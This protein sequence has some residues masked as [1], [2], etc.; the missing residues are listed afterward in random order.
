MPDP[1]SFQELVKK[2]DLEAVKRA[3]HDEPA[4][5]A[6]RNEAGQSSFMLAK[7]YR[8]EEIAS[9]LQSVLPD[10]DFF[11]ACV[12]GQTSVVERALAKDSSLLES[13][14]SDGWTPLH[15]ASFFGHP[16]LVE[17]LLNAGAHVDSRSTNA[18]RNTPLHAG[19]AGGQTKV[20]QLLLKRGADANARQ[21]GGWT[22]LH[23]AA[24]SGNR[25]ML[26]ALLAH[27]AD[28]NARASNNQAALDLALQKGHGPIAALL[29][30]LGAKL[31]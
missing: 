29:E 6:A 8:R 1:N 11:E 28:L 13:H 31:G 27:G 5:A 30:E 17:F 26:E 25:E 14:N 10:L 16:E 9:Y 7:Y 19:A 20:V 15:L 2:G 21:E 4:L 23:A 18:M 12:A 22:A 24:L 3:V